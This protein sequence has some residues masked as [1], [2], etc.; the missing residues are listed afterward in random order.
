MAPMSIPGE[1]GNAPST[2]PNDEIPLVTL[3]LWPRPKFLTIMTN[4]DYEHYM[5][6]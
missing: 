6:A 1:E 4:C 3:V 2:K 5:Y